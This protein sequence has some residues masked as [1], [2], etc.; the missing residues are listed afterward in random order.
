MSKR[1]M[2]E[3]VLGLTYNVEIKR[4]DN[5]T[6]EVLDVEEK[7]NLVVT[8]GLNRVRDLIGKQSTSGFD[9]IAIG[10]GTTAP[11]LGDSALQTE[12]SRELATISTP[13]NGQV[14][15]EKVFTFGTGES[16]SITETGLFDANTAGTMLNRLTF[17]SKAVDINTDLSVAITITV[18]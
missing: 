7:H 18:A 2:D 5:R 12:Q 11:A 14:K 17:A 10:E 4:I 1:K 6:G 9:Y 16:Y 8:D 15:F 13:A 3:K